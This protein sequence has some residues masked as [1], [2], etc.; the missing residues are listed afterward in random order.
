MQ[1]ASAFMKEWVALGSSVNSSV[2]PWVMN[3]AALSDNPKDE[4]G[5][6]SCQKNRTCL[7]A[8]CQ[9]EFGEGGIMVLGCFSGVELGFLVPVKRTLKASA[10]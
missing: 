8:S 5:F 10:Y 7:S 6:G 2:A 9:V 1:T 3:H 4:S